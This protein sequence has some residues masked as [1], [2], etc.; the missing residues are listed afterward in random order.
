MVGR[1][2]LLTVGP[3][4]LT[5]GSYCLSIDRANSVTEPAVI[6]ADDA[7][8]TSADETVLV[9]SKL[10]SQCR[11]VAESLQPR[12]IPGSVI[13]V[14][15]PFVVAGNLPEEQLVRYHRELILPIS[16]ALETDFF[17]KRP[18]QPITVIL[19]AG[20]RSYREQS[21]RLDDVKTDCYF[22]YYE[23][24]ERRVVANV[25]TGNGTLAHEL[26]HALA[27]FDFPDIP[28]WFDEGLATVF[29]Q[30]EFTEDGLHLVGLS[31]WRQSI[32]TLAIKRKELRPLTD[33][34]SRREIR[35]GREEIDYAH[36]RYVCLYLQKRRLLG[37]F[38]RKFRANIEH[39]PQGLET[40]R[41]LLQVKSLDE[42]DQDFRRW[43]ISLERR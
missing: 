1:W 29:E 39:D 41:A 23:R 37:P 19:L 31:N 14:R 11:A 10:D 15:S 40:L 27:H 8:T 5:A 32:L 7:G 13:L 28:E 22:G 21:R 18:T 9:A 25:A 33:L 35:P 38:Y 42:T 36:A 12:L 30:S 2:I 34:L 24:N 26:T 3:V 6:I 20:D 17:D 4:L 16:Q 43:V